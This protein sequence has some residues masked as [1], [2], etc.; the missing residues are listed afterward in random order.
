MGFRT[1][2]MLSNDYAHEWENDPLLGRKIAEAMSWAHT[3][4]NKSGVGNYGAVV[5]CVHADSQTLVMLD[6]YR[7][8][9][10]LSCKNWQ[11]TESSEDAAK[12][13]LASAAE[14]LGYK[15]VK[16]PSRQMKP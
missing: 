3:D 7:G 16:N 9:N 2:V 1:V 11:N 12:R 5:E 15:L 10:M 4:E 8:Y 6:G 14:S 13:L